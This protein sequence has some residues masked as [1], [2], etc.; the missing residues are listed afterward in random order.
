MV[1]RTGATG[2]LWPLPS[3]LCRDYR[4]HGAADHVGDSQLLL[5]GVG[6]SSE[7]RGWEES[8]IHSL[9]LLSCTCTLVVFH[10]KI[11]TFVERLVKLTKQMK[12]FYLF[13]PNVILLDIIVSMLSK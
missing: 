8:F 12:Y 2:E 6:H 9:M 7:E 5:G 4:Q 10:L 3:Q 11:K 13:I 1:A